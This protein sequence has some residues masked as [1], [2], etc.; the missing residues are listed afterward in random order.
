MQSR[1]RE[2][3]EAGWTLVELIVVLS[4]IA[5]LIAMSLPSLLG[6]R[7]GAYDMEAKMRLTNAAKVEAALAPELG[8]FTDDATWLEA[9]M[10]ELDFSG[11]TSKSIH[12]ALGQIEPG[13]RGRV[14]LY[15]RSVT[16]DWFG[17]QLV[18]E[19]GDAGRHTCKGDLE[20]MTLATCTGVAW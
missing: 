20:D 16:G 10:P 5:M 17:L 8:G 13:D 3:T 4:V 9:V 2:H 18:L 6:V 19:G 1:S 12:V 7:R 14:L 15:S 11:V